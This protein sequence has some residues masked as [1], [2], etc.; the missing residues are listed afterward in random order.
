L[1]SGINADQEHHHGADLARKHIDFLAG[2]IGARPSCRPGE[3]QAANYAAHQL[4]QSGFDPVS[5]ESFRG[6]PSSYARYTLAMSMAGLNA[7][8]LGFSPTTLSAALLIIT[9]LLAVIAIVQE[10]DFRWNWTHILIPSLPS[11]NVAAQIPA[12]DHDMREI[13]LVAHLDTHRTPWFNAS[14]IGQRLFR[15]AFRWTLIL[16]AI[17]L[18]SGPVT[19]L[20]S[21]PAIRWGVLSCGIL[22]I[23]LG[24]VFLQAD[25]TS[26]SPGAYDNASGVGSLLALGDRLIH[27]PLKYCNLW[28]L[29]TGCEETGSAGMQSFLDRHIRSFRKPIVINLDQMGSEELYARTCEGFIVRRCVETHWLRL[30]NQ[31]AVQ[32]GV[33][34]LQ[35]QSQAYSD[36]AVALQRGIP[37]ISLGTQ[38][39]SPNGETHRHQLS[40]L[41]MNIS[42]KG[43]IATQK[44]MW[45]L[46]NLIDSQ[47][48][49]GAND[50]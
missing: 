48:T 35:R 46:L 14:R 49:E 45:A 8:L 13:I 22:L 18:V 28:F 31:A 7:V 25:L 20:S 4:A 16:L 1:R 24:M 21:T 12:A 27:H 5:M 40:D 36:A 3:R 30:A 11:I 10:S 32:A 37:A 19:L 43:L 2:S 23:M 39:G 6:S 29:F 47:S 17:C 38:P 41:P 15:S 42:S 44:F 33:N 34:L 50:G 26:F 9:S